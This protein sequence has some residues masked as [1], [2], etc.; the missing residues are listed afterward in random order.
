MLSSISDPE[1]YIEETSPIKKF[2]IHTDTTCALHYSS[3]SKSQHHFINP[4]SSHKY[5]KS[6]NIMCYMLLLLFLWKCI[7][8]QCYTKRHISSLFA[9]KGLILHCFDKVTMKITLK[10]ISK[11]KTR[12]PRMCLKAAG[13]KVRKLFL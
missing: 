10:L 4:V 2:C 6:L 3:Q 8:Y 11:C 9:E 12:N 5:T 13:R 7:S 1:L